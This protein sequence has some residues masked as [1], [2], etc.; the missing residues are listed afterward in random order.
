MKQHKAI[1]QAGSYRFYDL[2][3]LQKYL[4]RLRDP[5]MLMGYEIGVF[6]LKSS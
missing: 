3:D 5:I 4:S 2:V 6:V 1:I